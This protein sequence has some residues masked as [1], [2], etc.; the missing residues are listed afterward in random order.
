MK[1]RFQ[2]PLYWWVLLLAGLLLVSVSFAVRFVKE[3]AGRVKRLSL[4]LDRLR[5]L[6]TVSQG[7]IGTL[8]TYVEGEILPPDRLFAQ[9]IERGMLSFSEITSTV[10]PEGFRHH[11]LRI[12][13]EHFPPDEVSELVETA[14]N[15]Q[16]AWRLTSVYVQAVGGKLQGELMMEALDKAP[17]E[18]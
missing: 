16:P 17:S 14:E 1:K 7:K 18:L 15:A 5:E 10:L 2:L 9:W 4:T 12:Q 8:S 6:Q 13:M 11:Q 3:E